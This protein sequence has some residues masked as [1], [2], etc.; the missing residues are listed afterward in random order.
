[1]KFHVGS[2]FQE[3]I[4]ETFYRNLFKGIDVKCYS[5]YLPSF[6]LR[7]YIEGTHFFQSHASSDIPGPRG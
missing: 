6:S 2:D 5:F 4:P 7:T 3:K 1:M